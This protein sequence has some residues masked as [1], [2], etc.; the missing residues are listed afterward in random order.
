VA[1][2]V[3]IPVL[4]PIVKDAELLLHMPPVEAH[5]RV[6]VW[7]VQTNPVPV[8]GNGKELAVTTFVTLQPVPSE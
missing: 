4:E 2:P 5:V 1:T 6:V 8:I 7:P 3:T